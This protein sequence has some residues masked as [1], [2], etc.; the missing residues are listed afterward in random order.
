MN[1]NVKRLKESRT[2]AGYVTYESFAEALRKYEPKCTRQT[3]HSWESGNSMP[4]SNYVAAIAKVLKKK[5][6]Y[7]YG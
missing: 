5:I 6:D 3:V 4:G 1:F 2:K 7:F